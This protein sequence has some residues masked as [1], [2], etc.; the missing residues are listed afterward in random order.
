MLSMT[1]FGQSAGSAEEGE[2]LLQLAAVNNRSW[3]L[4]LRS[5][6]HDLALEELV[7]TRLRAM[8]V[9]GS[10]TAQISWRASKALTV[11]LDA[12]E[13]AW[14]ELSARAKRLGIPP[15][16][17]E[18]AA[19]L[20][21][22]AR[23]GQAVP[24]ALL[25]RVLDE[26]IAEL[27]KMRRAEGEALARDL[28]SHG[29]TLRRLHAELTRLSSMRMPSYREALLA[30]LREALAGV[31]AVTPE[32]LVRELALHA[33]RIDVS[34][35]LVRLATHLDALDALLVSAEDA[36]GRKLEFLLT[37]C[38]REVATTSAKANDAAMTKVALDA[39]HVIE[40]MKEQAANVA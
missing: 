23:V 14:L 33:D 39:K 27:T 35:E 26:A 7:R 5:D 20:V 9:R 22:S 37:E 28:I 19:A 30:R 34:E 11:D 3:N 21:P 16:P 32:L 24:S 18:A 13:R 17:L 36:L 25:A 6:L 8:L 40:Q 15:P 29:R 12:V 10:L 4:H 2:L 31:A 1:G 38:G